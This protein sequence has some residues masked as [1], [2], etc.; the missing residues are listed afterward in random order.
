MDP[1]TARTLKR[2]ATLLRKGYPD[3]K[4]ILFGSKARGDDWGRS[5]YD[6]I[7]VSKHFDAIPWLDRISSVLKNWESI[8]DVDVLP[9]TPAEFEEKKRESRMVS[10]AAKEGVLIAK[11]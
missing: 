10:T 1:K 7:V 4:I 3:V 6:V 8:D 5:D 2:F 9:Y 11:T